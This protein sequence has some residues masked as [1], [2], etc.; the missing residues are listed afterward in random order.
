MEHLAWGWVDEGVVEENVAQTTSK[1]V[2]LQSKERDRLLLLAA[3]GMCLGEGCD[4][5]DA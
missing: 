2:G 3:V 5:T 1:G 4:D